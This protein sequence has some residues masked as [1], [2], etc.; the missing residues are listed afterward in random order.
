LAAS[1]YRQLPILPSE[2][3]FVERSNDDV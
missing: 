3:I 2:E 1:S